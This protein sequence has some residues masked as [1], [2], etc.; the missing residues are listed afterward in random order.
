[1]SG[2]PGALGELIDH[3]QHDG[4]DGLDAGATQ[5]L[6]AA[7]RQLELARVEEMRRQARVFAECFET[8]AGR[9]CLAL[10]DEKTIKRG[11][12]DAEMALTDPAAYALVAKHHAGA[13]QL[14]LQIHAALAIARGET[15][16]ETTS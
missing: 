1:M 11:E 4:W 15:K 2:L 10:L 5:K 9:R 8:E 3:M 13:R 14:V 6:A 12:T 7:Q 16:P